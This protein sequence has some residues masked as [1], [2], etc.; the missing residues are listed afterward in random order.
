MGAHRFRR[1]LTVGGHE[2]RSSMLLSTFQQRER[3]VDR[4][5][6]RDIS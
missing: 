6:S 1:G 5:R 4:D 2:S 3:I